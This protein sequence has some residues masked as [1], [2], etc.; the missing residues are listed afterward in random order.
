MILVTS[1]GYKDHQT[2]A[3]NKEVRAFGSIVIFR[4]SRVHETYTKSSRDVLVIFRVSRV[5]EMYTKKLGP[6]ELHWAYLG[7]R[8]AY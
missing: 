1:I 6:S 4:V 3:Y 7:V 2:R 5:H 8:W